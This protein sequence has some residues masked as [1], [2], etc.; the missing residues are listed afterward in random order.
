MSLYNFR[1]CRNIYQTGQNIF[2]NFL[3][4][5]GVYSMPLYYWLQEV[6]ENYWTDDALQIKRAKGIIRGKN[7]KAYSKDKA[8]MLFLIYT[9]INHPF[10]PI[11]IF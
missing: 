2:V 11:M 4:H 3:C 5:T 9:F 10:Y 6:K 8:L 1:F 7:D